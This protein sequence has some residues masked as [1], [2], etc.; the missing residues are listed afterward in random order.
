MSQYPL[1]S[2]FILHLEARERAP[3]HRTSHC[4]LHIYIYEPRQ[5]I[6]ITLREQPLTVNEQLSQLTTAL[7]DISDLKAIVIDIKYHFDEKRH[8]LNKDW[9]DLY[10]LFVDD[11]SYA[12]VPPS[13][14]IAKLDSS[15]RVMREKLFLVEKIQ[16]VI[17]S[18]HNASFFNQELDVASAVLITLLSLLLVGFISMGVAFCCLK[19]WYHQK[20]MAKARK[21]ANKA[22][23]LAIKEREMALSTRDSTLRL[24]QVASPDAQ[25]QNT[26]VDDNQETG[27]KKRQRSPT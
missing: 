22:K 18:E 10:V 3:P 6:K 14:V 5:L 16:L 4:K 17:V 11:R 8:R 24:S 21:A 26:N 13:R 23:Q 19:S 20:L 7:N 25:P 1:G 2:R 12:E 15:S 27:A 9:S